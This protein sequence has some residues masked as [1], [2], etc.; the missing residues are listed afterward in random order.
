MDVDWKHDWIGNHEVY[1]KSPNCSNDRK[2][3]PM[4]NDVYEIKD[5]IIFLLSNYLVEH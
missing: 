5:G 2:G 3:G 1:G 4:A